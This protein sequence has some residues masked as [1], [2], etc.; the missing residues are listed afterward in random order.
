MAVKPV[1]AFSMNHLLN[2]AL[3]VFLASDAGIYCSAV[4]TT[5][6]AIK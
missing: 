2:L 3:L 6:D 1:Q 4:E 5:E